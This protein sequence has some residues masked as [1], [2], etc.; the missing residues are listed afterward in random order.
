MT[1]GSRINRWA[2]C[3]ERSSSIPVAP[4]V[5]IAKKKL[6]SVGELTMLAHAI[7]DV[8]LSGE[9]YRC[10]RD[11]SSKFRRYTSIRLLCAVIYASRDDIPPAIHIRDVTPPQWTCSCQGQLQTSGIRTEMNK[12]FKLGSKPV[13][14]MMGPRGMRASYMRRASSILQHWNVS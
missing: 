2:I 9:D 7:V 1:I 10:T 3:L 12:S 11:G 6:A 13:R 8:G 5:N 4:L 14:T